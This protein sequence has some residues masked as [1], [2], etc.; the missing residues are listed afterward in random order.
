MMRDSAMFSAVPKFI[1]HSQFFYFALLGGY[2]GIFVVV[3]VI[4]TIDSVFA[5]LMIHATNQFIILSEELNTYNEDHFD[6]CY[7][8]RENMRNCKCMRCIINGHVNILRCFEFLLI[9]DNI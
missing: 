6:T 5:T 2:F 8:S 7:K 3:L 4:V 9:L 1:R